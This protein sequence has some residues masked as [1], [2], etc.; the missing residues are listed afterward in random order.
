MVQ[1]YATMTVTGEVVTRDHRESSCLLVI[2]QDVC[3]VPYQ[4]F[5]VRAMFNMHCLPA[6]HSPLSFSGAL[7]AFRDGE[8][9]IEINDHSHF[10]SC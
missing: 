10:W 2:W 1:D 5:Y 3:N 6:L 8:A 9:V 7:T 4:S